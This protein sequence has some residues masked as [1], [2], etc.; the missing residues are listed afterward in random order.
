MTRPAAIGFNQ[1]INQQERPVKIGGRP[2]F[3]D[4]A[5]WYF[6]IL[7]KHWLSSTFFL[8]GHMTYQNGHITFIKLATTPIKMATSCDR[9]G[10]IYILIGNAYR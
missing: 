7:G 8:F 10:H 5:T 1:H 9:I 4:L 6:K 2:R 3:L